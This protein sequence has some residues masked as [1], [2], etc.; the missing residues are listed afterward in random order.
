[1][2]H[3]II[4][5]IILLRE[6]KG[7]AS[8]EVSNI[9]EDKKP[10]LQETSISSLRPSFPSITHL[11]PPNRAPFSP[12]PTSLPPIALLLTNPPKN[13]LPPYVTSFP[14]PEKHYLSVKD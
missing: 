3:L 13:N 7:D 6:T 12:N 10:K 11:I 14:T 5:A 8:P 9:F 1:M 4:I 2:L